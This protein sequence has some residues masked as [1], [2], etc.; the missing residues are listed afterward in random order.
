MIHKTAVID[1][2]RDTIEERIS[3]N[4]G[5]ITELKESLEDNDSSKN[6][7]DDD[8][9]GELM[10]D[11]ERANKMLDESYQLK[12]EFTAINW[13]KKDHIT[14]G[15]LVVTDS[16]NFLIGL[17]L[18]EIAIGA[19]YNCFVI[20]PKAPIYASM[21]GKSVNENFTFNDKNYKVLEIS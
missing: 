17:S 13:S 16:L 8:G 18:G 14:D 9:S 21:K 10:A 11:F 6:A 20:S 1:T 2:C 15:A 3:R 5:R 4:K 19:Q 12:K 7:D